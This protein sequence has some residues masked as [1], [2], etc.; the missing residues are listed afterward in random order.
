[1]PD[2]APYSQRSASARV[3]SF[4]IANLLG[5][6]G[7]KGQSPADGAPDGPRERRRL[8]LSGGL[9][10]SPCALA[11]CQCRAARLDLGPPCC[12]LRESALA[13]YRG[14]GTHVAFIGCASPESK[15]CPA[16]CPSGWVTAGH[17]PQ[18]SS[19]LPGVLPAGRRRGRPH[20]RAEAR[21]TPASP[22][23]GP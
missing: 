5:A 4:F 14:G 16:V 1:M 3:S 20:H 8:L 21:Q 22:S 23:P 2:E 11:C 17:L 12:P 19:E 7:A 6:E 9:T 15:S 10:A 13:W 18:S